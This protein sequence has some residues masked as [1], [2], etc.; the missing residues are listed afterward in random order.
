MPRQRKQILRYLQGI[1]VDDLSALAWQANGDARAMEL[2]KRSPTWSW[3]CLANC[4]VSFPFVE[5][6]R[7]FTRDDA[8]CVSSRRARGCG[9]MS[10]R[11]GTRGHK[12]QAI[13]DRSTTHSSLSVSTRLHSPKQPGKDYPQTSP[14]AWLCVVA[15][16]KKGQYAKFSSDYA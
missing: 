16:T 15:C 8:R 3:A 9:L 14:A 4:E 6:E 5:E 7:V 2:L 12:T 11:Q 13:L 10:V 1:F